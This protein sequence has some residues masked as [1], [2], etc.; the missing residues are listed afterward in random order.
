MLGLGGPIGG[1]DAGKRG[2][3]H[4]AVIVCHV[5]E[6]I[7]VDLRKALVVAAF[8][9]FIPEQGG[10]FF[11]DFNLNFHFNG[12]RWSPSR[13]A[14]VRVEPVAAERATRIAGAKERAER[15]L[16]APIRG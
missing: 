3:I 12:V 2:F 5:L 14:A 11:G 7:G 13:R 10:G 15:L 4:Q 6:T 1:K 9:A 16:L 8:R